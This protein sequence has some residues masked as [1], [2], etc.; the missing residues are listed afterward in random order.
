MF[1]NM[2]ILKVRERERERERERTKTCFKTYIFWGYLFAL[3][4]KGHHVGSH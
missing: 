3:Q 4:G 1:Y 2:N